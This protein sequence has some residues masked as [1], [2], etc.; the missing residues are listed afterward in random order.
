MLFPAVI[1]TGCTGAVDP[2]AP[3]A[4]EDLKGTPVTLTSIAVGPMTESMDL[5][6]IS[7]FMLKTNI[8]SNATGYVHHVAIEAGGWVSRGQELF[9]IKTKEAQVLG[10]SIQLLDS[11]YAFS[12]EFTMKAPCSGY[13]VAINNRD[14]DFI[15][16]GEA[17]AVIGDETSFAFLLDLP[18][19]LMPLLELNK[20]MSVVLPDGTLLMGRLDRLMPSVDPIS[21]TQQAVIKVATDRHIPENLIA[22]VRFVK[23]SATHAQYLPKQAIL[24][25]EVQSHFWVMKLGDASTAVKVVVKTG[26][27]QGD[28][29][30]IISPQFSDTDKIILTGNYGL[31]D[32]AR[33]EVQK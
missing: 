8:K 5:N 30:E 31:S 3:M 26:I 10:N 15:Q 22:K 16:E 18:Y 1:F 9:R 25:D 17:V 4:T 20:K 7:A 29:V 11:S 23:S 21:Q 28:Q 2:S 32:T 6:A 27:Q 24:T 14:G 33:V 12:G 13:I 19:E